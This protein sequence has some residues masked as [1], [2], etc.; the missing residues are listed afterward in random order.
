MESIEN[1]NQAQ[2]EFVD[3]LAAEDL[4][5]KQEQTLLSQNY[6]LGL[7][8]GIVAGLVGAV[9]W[10]VIT[11]ATEYQIGYMAIAIGL[12][13]GF[14]M[15]FAGKG[16][17]PIFAITGGAI[18][19]LSCVLGNFLSLIGF[20]A[21]EEGL[22]YFQVINLIDFSAVPSIMVETFNPM[23]LLFYGLA[24]YEGYKFSVIKAE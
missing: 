16:V 13:V 17:K 15:R 22:G 2:Q 8:A 12:M 19:F 1:Q 23:D 5:R 7:I 24:I 20:L 21:N 18:A 9:L 6:P 10:A 3:S 4:K 14:S 11:V